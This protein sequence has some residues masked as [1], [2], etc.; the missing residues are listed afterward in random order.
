VQFAGDG[1]LEDDWVPDEETGD[2]DDI[3]R[4]N[5]RFP[6]SHVS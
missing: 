1:R 5:R 2:V 4:A 6:F 3:E